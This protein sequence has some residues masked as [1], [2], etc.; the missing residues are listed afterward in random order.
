MFEGERLSGLVR[1][2]VP[3]WSDMRPT[4]FLKTGV[5]VKG[6]L[7]LLSDLY[8]QSQNAVCAAD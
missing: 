1:K 5:R 4:A 3:L 2:R 8:V 7:Q 6:V